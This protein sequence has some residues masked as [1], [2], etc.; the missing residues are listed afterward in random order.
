MLVVLLQF[1]VGFLVGFIVVQLVVLIRRRRARRAEEAHWERLREQ[2]IP[3]ALFS[4]CLATRNWGVPCELRYGH[5]GNHQAHVWVS[6]QEH[7]Q[8]VQGIHAD[9]QTIY[10]PYDYVRYPQMVQIYW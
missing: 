2:T 3:I 5:P 9:L 4:D 7:Y 6:D 8:S 10:D 1:A